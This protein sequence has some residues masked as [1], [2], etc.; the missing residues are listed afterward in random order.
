MAYSWI[1]IL[2]AFFE[3]ATDD[4]EAAPPDEGRDIDPNELLQVSTDHENE[5]SSS[6]PPSN[7]LINNIT[8]QQMIVQFLKVGF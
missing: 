3:L 6:N 8:K 2:F 5:S 7:G 1:L 4:E